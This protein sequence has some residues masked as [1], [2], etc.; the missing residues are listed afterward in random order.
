MGNCWHLAAR[1][2]PQPP[3]GARL[4]AVT[5]EGRRAFSVPV[6]LNDVYHTQLGAKLNVLQAV[7][8][9]E[10]H[11]APAATCSASRADSDSDRAGSSASESS[12][13]GA[14]A[15]SMRVPRT[16]TTRTASCPLFETQLVRTKIGA[17]PTAGASAEQRALAHAYLLTYAPFS[18]GVSTSRAL[19]PLCRLLPLLKC[20]STPTVAAPNST[21]CASHASHRMYRRRLG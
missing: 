16:P 14:A 17:A 1:E 4:M 18:P 13:R 15:L 19:L 6:Q 7:I 9:R 12:A 8:A 2:S 21:T 11:R 20:A 10:L 3:S 5:M